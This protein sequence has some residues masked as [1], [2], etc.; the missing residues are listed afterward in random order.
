MAITKAAIFRMRCDVIV[1][2]YL[3]AEGI[4][5][6]VSDLLAIWRERCVTSP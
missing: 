2:R 4:A 1:L 3:P 6:R 5:S